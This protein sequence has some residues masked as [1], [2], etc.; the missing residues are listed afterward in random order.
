MPRR[1]ETE[2]GC[3]WQAG[4]ETV[5]DHP[6]R[7]FICLGGGGPRDNEVW[8]HKH[9]NKQEGEGGEQSGMTSRILQTDTSILTCPSAGADLPRR[10]DGWMDGWM[11]G[12]LYMIT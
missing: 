7:A 3:K 10:R 12:P 9:N 5:L 4:R 11:D 6:R 2:D 8:E 1:E